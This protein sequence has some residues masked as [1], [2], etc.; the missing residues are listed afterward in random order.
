MVPTA[1]Y[2]WLRGMGRESAPGALFGLTPEELNLD[3][4]PV[5]RLI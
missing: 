1:I 3:L 2:V 5:G 4:G